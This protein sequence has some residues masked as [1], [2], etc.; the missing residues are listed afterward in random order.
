MMAMVYGGH[1]LMSSAIVDVEYEAPGV[2]K[3]LCLK[4]KGDP[5]AY[6]A[7]FGDRRAEL[8]PD[9]CVDCK[10][11]GDLARA[12]AKDWFSEFPKITTQRSNT[13]ARPATSRSSSR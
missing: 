12:M 1:N 13:G 8:A 11:R 4:C 9:G 3:I 5:K 7:A 2:G 10:N 6:S